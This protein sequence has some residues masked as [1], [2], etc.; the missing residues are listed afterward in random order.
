MN[1][2]P[3]CNKIF[4]VYGTAGHDIRLLLDRILTDKN[5]LRP[6]PIGFARVVFKMCRIHRHGRTLAP[7]FGA[8]SWFEPLRLRPTAPDCG[9][10]RRAATFFLGTLLTS[11]TPASLSSLLSFEI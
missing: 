9:Q 4:R 5:I 6:R 11:P 10:L 1:M 2:S 7:R 3:R 8:L